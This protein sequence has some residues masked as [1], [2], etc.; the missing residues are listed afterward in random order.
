MR[1]NNKTWNFVAAQY[2][3]VHFFG[4]QSQTQTHSYIFCVDMKQF[5]VVFPRS[6]EWR[7]GFLP[8]N[9]YSWWLHNSTSEH[10]CKF[11]GKNTLSPQ[12][13]SCLLCNGKWQQKSQKSVEIT[14]YGRVGHHILKSW[15]LMW[16]WTPLCGFD[17]HNSSGKAFCKVLEC[18]CGN[19]CSFSHLVSWMRMT[20]LQWAL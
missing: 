8:K 11:T 17:S 19:F 13:I 14:P 15:I 9:I 4:K 1:M 12:F 7:Q 5:G 3:T 18:V 20:G 6:V 10:D 16:S 2:F